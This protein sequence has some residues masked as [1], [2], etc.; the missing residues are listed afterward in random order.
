MV[1]WTRRN[2]ESRE[3]HER[4]LKWYRALPE[5]A[6]RAYDERQRAQWE[7]DKRVL[8][9]AAVVFLIGLAALVALAPAVDGEPRGDGGRRHHHL[10]P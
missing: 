9:A 4:W 3:R 5:D 8:L 1:G 10:P 2:R 6:R 7:K